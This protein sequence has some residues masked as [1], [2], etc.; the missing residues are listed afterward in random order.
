MA[1][2]GP[3]CP[4]ASW[5]SLPPPD[6]PPPRPQPRPAPLFPRAGVWSPSASQA[7][8]ACRGAELCDGDARGDRGGGTSIQATLTRA[9]RGAPVSA[10]QSRRGGQR[11]HLLARARARGPHRRPRDRE[12]VT[13]KHRAPDAAA[14]L[15]WPLRP[16]ASTRG[17]WLN[18]R[19]RAASHRALPDLTQRWGS[20]H[21]ASPVS[22]FSLKESCTYLLKA[23]AAD[24]SRMKSTLSHTHCLDGSQCQAHVLTGKSHKH[25]LCF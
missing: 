9:G 7:G 25:N 23:A 14:W 6:P 19:H 4:R 12:L 17:R 18:P 8:R 11:C 22:A 5:A 13:R 21:P 24:V 2:E 3:L 16:G 20:Y 10:P 15:R 1:P